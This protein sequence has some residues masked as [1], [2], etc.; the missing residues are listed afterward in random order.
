VARLSPADA[1]ALGVNS[2]D[3]VTV[4]G[5]LSSITLPLVVTGMV[6]GVVWLPAHIDGVATTGRL[7]ATVSDVVQVVPAAAPPPVD[8]A[9]PGGPADGGSDHGGSDHG[10]SDH[11]GSDQGIAGASGGER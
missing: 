8:G 11:D 4:R 2:G 1:A 7:G 6:N 5:P 9:G 3:T 10:G